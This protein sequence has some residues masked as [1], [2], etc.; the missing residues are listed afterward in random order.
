MALSPKQRAHR[1]LAGGQQRLG[2][3]S[4]G[5]LFSKLPHKWPQIF[6]VPFMVVA[7]N[8]HLVYNG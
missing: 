1:D 2:V 8:P 3:P 6:R 4:G 7:D 5:W